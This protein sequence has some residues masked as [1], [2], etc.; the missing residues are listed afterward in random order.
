MKNFFFALAFM[1]MGTFAF[2]NTS[3]TNLEDFIVT[4]TEVTATTQAVS[5]VVT[6]QTMVQAQEDVIII[7]FDDGTVII[8]V[9]N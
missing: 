6:S 1:L 2:A 7:I 4:N 9:T 3:E 5:E 8:I